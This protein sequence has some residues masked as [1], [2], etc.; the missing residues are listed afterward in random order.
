MKIV[1]TLAKTA[2]KPSALYYADD[3]AARYPALAPLGEPLAQAAQ[4]ACDTHR[5]GG[6]VLVC[7]NGGSAADSDHIVGELV[8]G[9]VLPRP[10]PAL[11][12]ARLAGALPDDPARAARLADG[13]Q[14]GVAAIALTQHAALVTAVANDGDASLIF[15]QQVYAYGKEGDV[16]LAISTSG[17]S[18]NIVNALAVARAIGVGTIGLTGARSCRMDPLCDIVLKAPATATPLIQELHLPLYHAFCLMVEED[19]F[20]GVDAA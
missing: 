9:F 6:V 15:A 11:D 13:L 3:L 17:N 19:L 10:I 7:G 2:L 4:W 1:E 5:A 20:G 12:R 16:L 18:E 14:Q 8:K